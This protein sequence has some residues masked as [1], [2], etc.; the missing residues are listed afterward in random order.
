MDAVSVNITQVV[1][2]ILGLLVI[3][4]GVLV[5]VKKFGADIPLTNMI[6]FV[7]FGLLVALGMFIIS[8]D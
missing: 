1:G 2:V 7:A 5:N 4:A 3:A 8:R 6:L